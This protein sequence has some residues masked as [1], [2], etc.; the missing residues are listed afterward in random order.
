[1]KTAD[2]F[3][4]ELEDLKLNPHYAK[5]LAAL[6]LPEMGL[7]VSF[8]TENSHLSREEFEMK[9]NRLF[10]D[11]PNPPSRLSTIQEVL[12]ALNC[13]INP[14]PE[15][16][17]AHSIDGFNYRGEREI[18]QIEGGCLFSQNGFSIYKARGEEIWILKNSES[19]LIRYTSYE[20][21]HDIAR[22]HIDT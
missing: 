12:T 5:G 10:L 3:L 15:R 8:I 14:A 22:L 21:A 18:H 17:D 6:N 19:R 4:S 2:R 9:K 16:A 13:R 20:S 11:R 7:L 1:M